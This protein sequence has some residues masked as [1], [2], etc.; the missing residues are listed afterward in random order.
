M[1]I[2]VV[3]VFI[4]KIHKKISFK[5]MLK[6]ENILISM[7]FDSCITQYNHIFEFNQ[8]TFKSL[9]QKNYPWL[10]EYYTNINYVE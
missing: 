1:Y 7:H 8:T 2:C 4:N 10:K 3:K 5:I 9:Y 6:F